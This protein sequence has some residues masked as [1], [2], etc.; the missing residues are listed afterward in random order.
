MLAAYV[1]LSVYLIISFI[2][3]PW[4]PLC[5]PI[6]THN[7][8]SA[9]KTVIL[10]FEYPFLFSR[11]NNHSNPS[12]S[13]MT[14]GKFLQAPVGIT[15]YSHNDPQP[16]IAHL[17]AS[18]FLH[19]AASPFTTGDVT[20]NPQN[21]FDAFPNSH[22]T[23]HSQPN[24]KGLFKQE[25][26]LYSS[27]RLPHSQPFKPLKSGSLSSIPHGIIDPPNSQSISFSEHILL[28]FP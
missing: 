2:K 6:F 9:I 15:S 19:S 13:S 7:P 25:K 23:G 26:T 8:L 17:R 27:L 28:V 24:I 10:V 22:P 18:G 20:Q 4:C 11:A 21:T 1:I 5:L 12:T 3:D 14:P 16:H